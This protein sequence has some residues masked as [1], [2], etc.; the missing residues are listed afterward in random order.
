[1]SAKPI[2]GSI[3]WIDLTVEDATGIR[4]FYAAVA[5]WQPEAVDMGEYADFNMT[6]AGTPVAGVCHA[7]GGNAGL[8]ASWLIY[9]V[10]EDL[11]RS[12]SNCREG[13]GELL[14]EVKSMGES[15]YCVIRDP[16]GACCALYQP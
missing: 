14:G 8:P 2:P 11:D 6:A 13:G 3:G 15:R 16:A 9:I 7:R 10:V 4:D 5:G 1:M 12:I